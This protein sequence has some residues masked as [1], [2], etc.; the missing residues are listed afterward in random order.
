MYKK[1][2]DGFGKSNTFPKHISII[3]FWVKQ[4]R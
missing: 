4:D 2:K 1:I 3:V